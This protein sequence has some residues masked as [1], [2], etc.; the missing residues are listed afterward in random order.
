MR[1]IV[2]ISRLL[3]MVTAVL[4]GG[5]NIILFSYVPAKIGPYP[6]SFWI[7]HYTVRYILRVLNVDVSSSGTDKLHQTHGF[8]I[9][10]HVSYLDILVLVSIAPVRFVAKDEIRTWP[11]IGRIARAIGCVFVQRSSKE[12][13]QQARMALA[14]AEWHPPIVIYAEGKRGPG[15]ELL[16]FRYGAFEI[17]AAQGQPLLPGAIV[18]DPLEIALWPR[19]EPIL[20]ALWRLATTPQGVQAAVYWQDVVIPGPD[21][22]PVQ[23]SLDTHDRLAAL[24]AEKQYDRLL[25]VRREA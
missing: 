5:T 6:L 7:F 17:A 23:L 9:A 4:I 21:S 13:R 14:A 2:G 15:T 16:P 19:R 22:D 8:V 10:N 25:A 12:S 3:L 24:L 1:K 18:Y 20:Q 11:V